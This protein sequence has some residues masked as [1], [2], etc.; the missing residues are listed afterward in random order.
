ML[1]L[2]KHF[3][4]IST[5]EGLLYTEKSVCVSIQWQLFYIIKIPLIM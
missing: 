3:L 1:L 4:D 2:E 5:N